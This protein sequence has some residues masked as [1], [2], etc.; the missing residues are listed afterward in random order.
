[1]RLV[2]EFTV[3]N[4]AV[5]SLE[6]FVGGAW[7]QVCA[8]SFD[9]NEANI[10]CGQLGY[11]A[12]TAGPFFDVRANAGTTVF[13]DVGITLPGCDGSESTLVECA[14]GSREPPFFTNQQFNFG[15]RGGS[16]PGVTL[17]CVA[18]EADG[19]FRLRWLS[20]LGRLIGS[21]L[22]SAE[23]GSAFEVHGQPGRDTEPGSG[24]L[25]TA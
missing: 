16:R 10:A 24:F 15:C 14:A 5:G 4:W 8:A 6:V 1:M 20:T 13:S 9:S 7:R 21:P 23:S 2:D 12:G 22:Q 3:A 17:A 18:S 25:R 19:V 11:G